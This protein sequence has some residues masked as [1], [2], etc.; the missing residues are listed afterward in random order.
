MLTGAF[1]VKDACGISQHVFNIQPK[2][3][4][5]RLPLTTIFLLIVIFH[6]FLKEDLKY[7][8]K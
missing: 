2:P 1:K 6:L 4:Q 7:A 3:G 8:D 5:V